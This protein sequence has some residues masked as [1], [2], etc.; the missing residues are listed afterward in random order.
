MGL[1]E[2]IRHR[3]HT[4]YR[5]RIVREQY[6]ML[7]SL[8]R[9]EWKKKDAWG[10]VYMLHHIS[11]KDPNGIPTNEDLKVSPAFLEH[12]IEK[13]KKAGFMFL[14]LDELSTIIKSGNKPDKPFVIFTI[15]DG[16]ID[17]YT[18]ALPI[19]EKYQVPFALFIATDFINQRSILWWDIIEDLVLQNNTIYFCEKPF[20]CNSFQEKW[21]TYRILREAILKYDQKNL[22]S[23]LQEAFSHYTIDWYAPIKK[24]AMSWTQV[25]ELS[26]HPLC[27]IGGHTVSHPALNKLSNSEFHHEI[28]EGVAILK[29][30]T[31][32]DI[33]HFAYPYGSANEIGNR[34]QLLIK[35]FNFKTVFSSYGGCIT[36]DN[37]S[38]TNHLPR[39]TLHECQWHKNA[40]LHKIKNKFK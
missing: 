30:K 1:V 9:K 18:K 24:Q 8:S 17:N 39:V 28:A 19:F 20:S 37:K 31:S 27:T 32:H 10:T 25:K 6:P 38:Q 14:T 12:I 29:D 23:L 13:Y 16:Y 15:D 21:D 22:F 34:E 4:F 35:E 26:K 11:D 5:Q 2:K 7:T 40:I 33:Y 3:V 36:S